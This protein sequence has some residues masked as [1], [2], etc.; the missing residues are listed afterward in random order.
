MIR[1][2][3]LTLK[4]D[5]FAFE[6]KSVARIDGMVVFVH[7]G[8]PGD[9]VRARVVKVKKQFVEA[10]ALEILSPSALRVHPLCRYFG[11]CGGCK[12]QDVNY[13]AQ[14]DFKR[15]H[16]VDA[17]ERIGGFVG[18]QVNP[19]LGSTDIYYYRNKMEFSF[20]ERWLTN[21][22]MVSSEEGNSID[23]FALGLHIPQRYDRVLDLEECWL[24]SE[25]SNR[26]VNEVRK[27]SRQ[28]NLAI[29]STET[30]SGYL[31]NLVIREA[32][33]TNELMVNLV[34]RDD[35]P[36]LT[37]ELTGL[38]LSAIPSITTVVN[39]I[40]DRK[41]QVAI[42]DTEKVYHGLGYIT[43]KIGKRTYRI[44]ANS[45]FQTNTLQAEHLYDTAR[46][47]AE[48]KSTDVLFDLYSGTGTIA[49]HVADDVAEVVGIE[50]VEAAVADAR[51]NAEHNSVTNC[52]FILGDL[53][54][55]LTKDTAW[56]QQ[57]PSPSVMIIDPPRSGMHDKV[58][59]EV[60]GMHP[61]R[62]VYVSC[63]PTTQAR[64]LK[65]LCANGAYTIIKVQ[66]VDMFPHTFHI[67]NVV[68][69]RAG[70][71]LHIPQ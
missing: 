32:K 55:R 62:I 54:D 46:R 70:N 13:Q 26:I 16:V 67:E 28:K 60:L 50:S 4:L 33:R 9:E 11:T 43:E 44:S 19:T 64:D 61:E 6:G 35:Q 59:K 47:M 63:N 34:T 12:W 25:R 40:T 14:L 42:G 56:L 1:G 10:K 71:P 48:L 30:H 5:S 21:E 18:V 7:G 27:F 57:H 2:D 69:L 22:E 31:R 39:N 41:S 15:Q 68:A 66:P 36:E 53:K 52:S 29:F 38:L 49:L 58:V 3:E 24:Q 51:K 20:G 37:N 23:R 45:F 8:V 65:L 17:L